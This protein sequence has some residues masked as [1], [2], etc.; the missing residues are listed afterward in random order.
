MINLIVEISIVMV[1]SWVLTKKYFDIGLLSDSILVCFTLFFAQIVL[2]ETFLGIIG[3]LY[4][5]NVFIAHFVA[6]LIILLVHPRK[7]MPVFVKPNAEPFI[8]NNLIL[9]AASVFFSFYLVSVYN[10]LINPPQDAD[11]LLYHLAFPAAW[12][13]SGSLNT[14]FFIFGTGPIVFPGSLAISTP[15]YYPINAELFFTWLMLPLRNA[16]LADLGQTP[17]YIIGIIAVYSILRKYNL[18]RTTALLSGFLWVL[19]PNIFKQLKTGAEID[20]ICTVLFLLIIFMVLLLKLNFTFKNAILFGASTGLFIGTKF[21]NFVYLIALLPLIFY[22]LYLQVKAKKF[23]FSKML[24]LSFVIIS[25][26]IL[27]GG[28]MYIKNYFFTG[29]PVFP[30]GIKVFGRNIFKGLLDNNSFGTQTFSSN[31]RNLFR[32]FREGLGIQFFALILPGTF[33]PLFFYRYLKKRVSPFGEYLLLFLTPLIALIL[34][35]I[36]INLYVVR[37]FFPYLS[38]GLLTTVIFVT[39]LPRAD[40]YLYIV[41]FISIFAAV[42]QLAH[43]YELVTSILLSLA[44][45][46]LLVHCK[47]QLAAFYKNKN[48]GRVILIGLF[49]GF[50]FL[51]Y[52]NNK[53]GNEEYDRYISSLS[54]KEKW[55]VDLRKGWK[56]LNDI[57]KEG[58]RVAYTGRQDAYPLYGRGLKNEVKYVSVNKKEIT[59]Y[60][61]PD[62]L[63][64][65]IKDFF[66]W[67]NN[68]KKERIEYLFIALPCLFNRE[69]DDPAKFPIEDEWAAMHPDDFQLLFNNSL[70]RIYK[71]SI[72]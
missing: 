5:A 1:S 18:S 53:Y 25:M 41:S 9:F 61:N 37:Y 47:T 50:L 30:V 20:V 33:L 55:Q 40:K 65:Q 38:L 34:V 10:N 44:C 67:R 28:Y 57:T 42:F 54:K 45:F 8:N 12:I 14:P 17:F 27:F 48:F 3:Q 52:L 62:G 56:A 16:F 6:L 26:I 70:S 58:Y 71:V 63:Y 60:N 32:I 64:R 59:P 35:K 68:L 24:Q 2:V 11:S 39:K 36:F 66:A 69:E 46:I 72:K 43:R 7:T 22:V 23:T 13:R 19:I 21:T 51:V 49:L 31:S 4:F 15:S 29:N